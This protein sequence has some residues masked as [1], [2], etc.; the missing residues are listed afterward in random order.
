M[1]AI[2]N[3]VL[4]DAT[5]PTPVNR[6]MSPVTI[7]GSGVAW[8]ANRSGGIAVGFDILSASVRSPQ[9]TNPNRV[10]RVNLKLA[11]PTLEVTSPST[12]TGIQ[13]A[14][15]KAYDNVFIGEFLL[16]ERGTLQNRKDLL[17]MV[18]D[19]LSD[20]VVTALVENLEPVY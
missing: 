15:T 20:A 11:L 10:Y 17:A 2:A 13:P 16:P 5:S 8:W 3:V 18:K 19:L 9:G 7:D 12:G 14:P 4:T 1:A 6:T